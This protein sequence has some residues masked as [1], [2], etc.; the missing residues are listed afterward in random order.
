VAQPRRRNQTAF[1]MTT[2]VNVSMP[3]DFVTFAA[4]WQNDGITRLLNYVWEGYDELCRQKPTT[5]NPRDEVSVNVHLAVQIERKKPKSCPFA[6]VHTPPELATRL[7]SSRPAPAPDFG[8]LP[9]DN[10]AVMLP[11]EAKVLKT[12]RDLSEYLKALRTRF[13]QCRYAPY[14]TEGVMLGY[15]LTGETEA[16]FKNLKRK[17]RVKLSLHHVFFMRPHLISEHQ[18]RHRRCKTSPTEFRCHHLMMAFA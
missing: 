16:A 17:L 8:F 3:P 13:L 2:V 7:A 9:L 4:T 14:S 11:L 10:L 18:R 5:L 6:F 15:L 1:C 12:E